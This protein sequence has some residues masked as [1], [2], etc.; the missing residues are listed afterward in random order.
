MKD[1]QSCMLKDK[2]YATVGPIK[3]IKAELEH[4]SYLSTRLRN[5]DLRE[6]SLANSD[7]LE[8]LVTPLTMKAPTYS[9][10]VEDKPICMF[11]TVPEQ[12][13]KHHAIVWALGSNTIFKY[14]KS[15]VKAS[16]S[17]VELLQAKNK[18]IWNIVPEDHY[19][20]ILW[21]RRLGFTIEGQVVN[22]KNT[23]LLHFTRC[24]NIK[25]VAVVH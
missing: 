17:M 10:M 21:L 14:K 4:A 25:N 22:I 24:Q 2:L 3:I 15:F 12:E 7:P 19:D 23:T 11:G 16:L 13:R 5:N 9:A 20:T 6:V 18:T 8:A 1:L